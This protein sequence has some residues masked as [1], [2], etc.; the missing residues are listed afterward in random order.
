MVF[1]CRFKVN[2]F[3]LIIKNAK[4]EDA[5]QYA[6]KAYNHLGTKWGNFTVKVI[7]RDSK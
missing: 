4:E 6:C 1:V 3:A 2:R 7:T 5:G